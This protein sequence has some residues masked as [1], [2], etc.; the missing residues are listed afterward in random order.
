VGDRNTVSRNAAAKNPYSLG[1]CFFRNWRDNGE[2]RPWG[3]ADPRGSIFSCG[4]IRRIGAGAGPLSPRIVT[5]AKTRTCPQTRTCAQTGKRPL[6]ESSKRDFPGQRHQ[7]FAGVNPAR[8]S[9][10]LCAP[11]VPSVANALGNLAPAAVTRTL[12]AGKHRGKGGNSNRYTAGS[13]APVSPLECANYIFLTATKT[14]LS[15]S[16][17][18][19]GIQ[20]VNRRAF[21]AV[22]GAGRAWIRLP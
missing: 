22:P 11:F 17:F 19:H 16:V 5:C 4:R 18:G 7:A 21:A 15:C 13:H 20:G 9:V 3:K 1:S 6:A 14:W 10:H 2:V 8:R 12:W